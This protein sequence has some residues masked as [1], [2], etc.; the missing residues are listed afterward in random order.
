MLSDG[1]GPRGEWTDWDYFKRVR[2]FDQQLLLGRV[3]EV[4]AR[5]GC[6]SLGEMR[7]REDRVSPVVRVSRWALADI[8]RVSLSQPKPPGGLNPSQADVVGL[9]NAFTNLEVP[10]GYYD[11]LG[12]VLLTHPL[13]QFDWQEPA[14]HAMSRAEAIMQSPV[15][16]G[17]KVLVGGWEQRL[18]GCTMKQLHA[19]GFMTM[20][21]AQSSSGWVPT[22]WLGHDDVRVLLAELGLTVEES[23][24]LYRRHFVQD[25]AAFRGKLLPGT[26]VPGVL[27]RFTFNP[28]VARPVI[29]LPGDRH[30][31]PVPE[32][33]VLK[34]SPRSFY[35]Q[36]L[37]LWGTQF[38]TEMGHRFE[39]Y[40]GRQLR[41]MQQHQPGLL[42]EREIT[43]AVRGSQA[44]SVD[45]IVTTPTT[46]VLIETKTTQPTEE[47][48]AGDN[49]ASVKSL[50]HALKQISATRDLIVGRHPA[51]EHIPD[52]RDIVGMVVTLGDHYT[53]NMPPV[54]DYLGLASDLPV[55]IE[56]VQAIEGAATSPRDF[57]RVVSEAIKTGSPLRKVD[58]EQINPILDEVWRAGLQGALESHR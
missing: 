24:C 32:A 9:C 6:R 31:A 20:A 58:A 1:E 8:A 3:A 44:K 37:D 57:G 40:V 17:D 55:A 30:L 53:L 19:L 23:E 41:V 15:S 25:R 18:L 11:E 2:R 26:A 33:M 14:V 43:Y 10:E 16:S 49:A 21:A 29:E 46:V 27:R 36:G 22:G 56:G 51:F 4:N 45:W 13:Q 28:L 34:L 48:R 35:Q 5:L 47:V 39:C 7:L 42:V 12:A 50:R 52:D 54:R 38:S